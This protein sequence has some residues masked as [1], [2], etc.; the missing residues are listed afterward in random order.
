[1]HKQWGGALLSG[2]GGVLS[3][4]ERWASLRGGD[5]NEGVKASTSRR[6]N[7]DLKTL[8][9][10]VLDEVLPKDAHLRLN[11]RPGPV[12]VGVTQLALSP[13][14]IRPQAIQTFTSREDLVECLLAS[15]CVPFWFTPGPFVSCRGT[16]AIDGYFSVPR[17]RFGCPYVPSQRTVL[18][19]PFPASAIARGG[20]PSTEEAAT[21]EW[22][23]PQLALDQ[24]QQ[25]GEEVAVMAD[26]TEAAAGSKRSGMRQLL[27]DALSS[28]ARE[29]VKMY[30]EQGRRDA[31]LWLETSVSYRASRRGGG[32]G[33]G[34][35]RSGGGFPLV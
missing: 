35:L 32:G 2:A 8:L 28:N 6:N 24:R 19:S 26:G 5:G 10:R 18:V 14:F 4:G 11:N 22:L 23:S 9:H 34:G 12:T 3:I 27:R 7:E 29:Q 15:C 16:P 21:V 20:S 31:Q 25:Q 30:F 17:H 13:L 1:M 33:A